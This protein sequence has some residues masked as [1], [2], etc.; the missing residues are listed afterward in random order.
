MKRFVKLL[1]LSFLSY[2]HDARRFMRK[3]LSKDKRDV[4]TRLL[5][6]MAAQEHVVEKGLT[7]PGMRPNFGEGNLRELVRNCETCIALGASG[8]AVFRDAVGV[9]KEY[10]RIHGELGKPVPQDILSGIRSLEES[11]PGIEPVRQ[12]SV[13]KEDMFARGDFE[14]FA[15]SRH[16]VR[17]FS[18]PVG[19]TALR[20]ALEL[21]AATTPSSC[22]RQS[23]RIHVVG[24]GTVFDGIL[25]LHHGNRGFGPKADKL[26][27]VSSDQAVYAK[28]EERNAVFVDGGIYAMNLLYCLHH[29]GIAACTLNCFFTPSEE[30]KVMDLL[31]T[32]DVPVALIAV[33][34]CPDEVKVARSARTPWEEHVR[35]HS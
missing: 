10:V 7:M 19:E 32:D 2:G 5:S 1:V 13:R 22:N 12:G 23:T 18:G 16:S 25:A 14:R 26:I 35:W 9:L 15:R 8:H 29:H 28:T 31:E 17:N 11:C 21:A 24:R 3:A 20:A 27:L 33:G 34:D 4:Q 30:R 6:K